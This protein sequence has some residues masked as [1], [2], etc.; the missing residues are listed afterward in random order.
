MNSCKDVIGDLTR[1]KCNLTSQYSGP[2]TRKLV[3]KEG[4][5]FG[6]VQLGQT[7]RLQII[8]EVGEE[9]NIF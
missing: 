3:Y 7:G 2:V 8:E 1:G 4:E 5:G 6:S 9:V